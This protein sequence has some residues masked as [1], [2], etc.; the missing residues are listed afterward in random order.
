MSTST[1]QKD[2][3]E[4]GPEC[5]GLAEVNGKVTLW[6]A[7]KE[8]EVVSLLDALGREVDTLAEGVGGIVKMGEENFKCF[9]YGDGWPAL[10]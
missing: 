1:E 6:H 10:N 4:A 7:G 8:Y 2:D 3:Q 9:T 5:D